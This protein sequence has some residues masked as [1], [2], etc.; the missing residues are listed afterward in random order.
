M[1]VFH[2]REVGGMGHGGAAVQGKER[3]WARCG[4]GCDCVQPGLPALELLF[5]RPRATA[6]KR[7]S[8]LR[9]LVPCRPP[10][11]SPSSPLPLTRSLPILPFSVPSLY[12]VPRLCLAGT[13]PPLQALQVERVRILREELER[14][15][16]AR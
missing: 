3:V 7:L 4:L 1:G 2:C 15:Q 11:F 12:P 8:I 16:A 5:Q 9:R 13:S 14:R 6:A 10:S